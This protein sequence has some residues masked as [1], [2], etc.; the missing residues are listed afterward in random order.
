[1]FRNLI[2]SLADRYRMLAPDY[3][4][5]GHRSMPSRDEFAY[6]FDNLA[7]FVEEFTTTLGVSST[8]STSGLRRPVGYR[9]VQGVGQGNVSFKLVWM[10]PIH[11]IFPSIAKTRIG[12]V[13]IN[14]PMITARSGSRTGSGLP[15]R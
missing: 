5:F 13:R 7:A 9:F 3:P 8:P 2:P 10:L 1:M 6:T 14:P 15:F 12:R 4:R 11:P